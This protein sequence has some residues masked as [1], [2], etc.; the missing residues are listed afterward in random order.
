MSLNKKWK[1][2]WLLS[3]LIIVFAFGM[4]ICRVDGDVFPP[5]YSQVVWSDQ[6]EILSARI[7]TD[8]Q[9]RM[10]PVEFS[11]HKFQRALLEFED[12]RFFQHIG[13]D[14][15]SLARALWLN[16]THRKVISGASTL[17][18]QIT[19]MSA[20]SHGRIHPRNY[21]N[22]LLEMA[23]ALQLEWRFSKQELYHLYANHAPFGGNIV[24]VGAASWKYFQCPPSKL[25]WGQAALL[26]V[27]PN[28]PSYLHLG[29][30]RELLKRKRDQLLI[31]LQLK[32][33]LS[34]EELS[35]A[36]EESLPQGVIPSDDVA[37][38]LLNCKACPKNTLKE[39][40]QRN[41]QAL[42]NQHIRN[43]SGE[44]IFNGAILVIDHQNMRPIVYAGNQ[45]VYP[46]KESHVDMIQAKRSPGSTLKPFLFGF[47]MEEGKIL[48][49]TILPDYPS[50]F[51]T[52]RPQNYSKEFYGAIPAWQALSESL[53][54]PAVHL[55]QQVGVGPF[56][57]HLRQWGFEHMQNTE[58][59][60]GLTLALGGAE[61]SLWELA[62]AYSRLVRVSLNLSALTAGARTDIDSIPSLHSEKLHVIEQG[63]AIKILQS[64][65]KVHK[66]QDA[67]IWENL[68]FGSEMA[69]KTGTSWG[70][71][72]A[73]AIGMIPGY[74][75]GIWIG[76]ATS[77]GRPDLTGVKKAA[78][79][80][81]KVE[82]LL[83]QMGHAGKKNWDWETVS[84][85]I[86]ICIKSGL[87]ASDH[88]PRKIVPGLSQSQEMEEC[89]Y[90][91][92]IK[93]NS[94]NQRVHSKCKDFHQAKDSVIFELPPKMAHYYQKHHPNEV[95][96][97]SWS[98]QCPATLQS[99]EINYPD[100]KSVV[101][102]PRLL[103]Q[104]YT[105]L[106]MEAN[107]SHPHAKLF[108]FL[109]GEYLGRTREIH[110]MTEKLG[111]GSHQLTVQ[112][113]DGQQK[114]VHFRI[115]LSGK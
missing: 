27:L 96:L 22:K 62:H 75:I 69:W 57:N 56:Q 39:D 79:L 112:D 103:N 23:Q 104:N 61:S 105:E 107:H 111:A 76:N 32:G 58:R 91:N 94:K 48:P 40:I 88:C 53:N 114:S 99:F 41:A 83:N 81:F 87:K 68:G 33:E 72:D 74:T 3:I 85:P 2:F 31:R 102:L 52:Y 28:N 12:Q 30:K 93:V 70:F 25:S 113:S 54:I 101:I 11:S 1:A 45:T 65:Q 110:Q 86:K 95:G 47:A 100:P 108:W 73:W 115:E 38:H 5:S 24:G 14:G 37:P 10:P 16:L 90:H 18:M 97:V 35:L 26:A 59:Y 19:R 36:L 17:T 106:V 89:P 109:N 20:R 51:G 44:E 98:E 78:P 21:L 34:K 84:S 29:S 6:G 42:L 7:A 43:I 80:L 71:R 13:V 60:Y 82:A 50:R 92:K 64:L 55:L 67:K 77:E 49:Q 4:R 15:L 9:W 63:T 46:H 66:P 8:G